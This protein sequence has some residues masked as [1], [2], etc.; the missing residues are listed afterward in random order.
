MIGAKDKRGSIYEV[1]MMPFSETH[2]R[3]SFYA[4]PLRYL[5]ARTPLNTH[6]FYLALIAAATTIFATTA[7]AEMSLDPTCIFDEG[8]QASCTHVVACIGGDTLFV[9][10]TTGWDAGTLA[11][12]LSSGSACTGT[13]DN[14][15]GRAQFSC[16]DA[17]EGEVIYTTVDD[18]TGTGIGT[19]PTLS[20]RPI[21]AWSG[22]NIA[23]YIERETGRVT[24]QCGVE[25]VLV[26]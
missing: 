4:L 13:W 12:V 5:R 14:S 21:E 9:G 20:G 16:D 10:G 22:H 7:H 8:S 6:P 1:K 23:S 3:N 25:D 24:M 11:G 19:G 26:S 17:E 2:I 18:A 15:T